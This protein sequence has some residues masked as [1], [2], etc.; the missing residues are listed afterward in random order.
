MTGRHDTHSQSD[1]RPKQ[2]DALHEVQ[3][4]WVMNEASCCW[5]HENR[6]KH[7]LFS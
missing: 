5:L 2:P 6:T 1:D 4:T 3:D 7:T